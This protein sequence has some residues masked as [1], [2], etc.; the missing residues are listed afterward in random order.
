MTQMTTTLLVACFSTRCIY[1]KGKSRAAADRA[2][3]NAAK[4]EKMEVLRP[5]SGYAVTGVLVIEKAFLP[6]MFQVFPVTLESRKAM[7]YNRVLRQV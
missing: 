3:D 5:H 7:F 4:V 1:E 2:K 6:S